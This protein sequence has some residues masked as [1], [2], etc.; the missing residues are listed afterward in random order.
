MTVSPSGNWQ[1]LPGSSHPGNLMPAHWF[2]TR[3]S[4]LYLNQLMCW[5]HESQSGTTLWSNKNRLKVTL[6]YAKEE[7]HSRLTKK[8]PKRSIGKMATGAIP[9]ATWTSGAMQDMR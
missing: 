9:V 7:S 8:P 3:I 5:I 1:K 2:T 6:K 4:L